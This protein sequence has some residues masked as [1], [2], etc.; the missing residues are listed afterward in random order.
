M[1]LQ[2]LVSLIALKYL[3]H[4]ESE[5]MPMKMF[6]LVCL[7]FCGIVLY[8]NASVLPIWLLLDQSVFALAT[9]SLT[10]K[11]FAFLTVLW[12]QMPLVQEQILK[13]ANATVD[14]TLR[15]KESKLGVS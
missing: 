15:Q 6:V 11:V 5:L 3:T 2:E 10:L 13:N 1:P 12:F 7:D 9:T 14:F 4:L 8:C